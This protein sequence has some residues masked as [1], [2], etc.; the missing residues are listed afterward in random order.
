ML[1]VQPFLSFFSK[2]HC[3]KKH[4]MKEENVAEYRNAQTIH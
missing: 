2:T 4:E 1:F 3:L